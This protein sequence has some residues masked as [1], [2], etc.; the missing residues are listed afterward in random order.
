MKH[1]LIVMC[2]PS[3]VGKSYLANKIQET[4][5]DCV[6]VSRDKI[7]FA[8][9]NDDDDY[10]QYEK[11]VAN[12]FY[13]AITTNLKNHRYV[14]ADATHITI[15][16]RNKLFANIELGDTDDIVA[17]WIEVPIQTALKQNA[18]RTGRARVPEDVIKNMY[19]NKVSPHDSECFSKIIFVN[20]EQ[21]LALGTGEANFRRVIDRL[22]SIQN[23]AFPCGRLSY[24]M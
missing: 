1:T 11:Q 19:K 6:I 21:D 10:F 13:H 20:P 9:L 15:G 12:N 16:S 24:A 2:G 18:V 4:H 3:G 8:L 17:V 23:Q 14:I 22:S 5:E 7:R